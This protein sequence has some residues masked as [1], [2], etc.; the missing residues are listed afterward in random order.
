MIISCQSSYLSQ[1]SKIIFVEKKLSCEEILGNF[2]KFCE[3]LR[4]FATIH[5]LSCG[6]K[7]SPKST[8]VEKNCHLE[9]VG[10]IL[11]KIGK[12]WENL[13]QFTRFHGEKN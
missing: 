8:F 9:K 7:M 1:I 6:E 5:A 4:D 13:P 3:I 12:F 2:E 10:D 11:G